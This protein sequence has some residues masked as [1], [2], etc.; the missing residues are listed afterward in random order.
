MHDHLRRHR[1][2]AVLDAAYPPDAL[3]GGARL[4]VREVA[5]RIA[6]EPLQG[7]N[8]AARD[9]FD[10]DARTQLDLFGR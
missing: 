3:L 4:T 8:A 5:E 7:G 9:L 2:R 10:T 1:P 6:S